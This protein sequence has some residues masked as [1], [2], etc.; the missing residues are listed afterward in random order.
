MINIPVS[1]MRFLFVFVAFASINFAAVAQT[2][3][4]NTTGPVDILD[5]LD[6]GPWQF[7]GTTQ[8]VVSATPGNTV[9]TFSVFDYD[10]KTV[11][12]TTGE[13][14]VIELKDGHPMLVKGAPDLPHLTTPIIIPN[15]GNTQIRVTNVEYTEVAGIEIAP[16]KGNLKRTINP[17]DVP[18]WKGPQYSQNQFYPTKN[19]ALGTPYIL[20]DY[21]GQAVHIYPIQ[22]NPVT[23]T[24][25][26]ATTITVEVVSTPGVGLNELKGDITHPS[27]DFTAIYQSHFVNYQAEKAMSAP[28]IGS[29]LIIT[30]PAFTNSMRPYVNW[31][32]RKG[33]PTEMVSIQSIGNTPTAIQAFIANYYATHNL[34]YVLLVGDI[35]Q[36]ASPTKSGG[37]SDPSYGYLTGTDSYAEVIVGRFSAE[38]VAH[39][40]TQVAKVL[41][42]E[43]T[44]P[45]GDTRFDHTTHIA[46]NEGPGDNNEMDWEHERVIRTKLMN[47]TYTGYNEYYDGT[48][49]GD[50]N[51]ASGDPTG[52]NI[53]GVVN[54]GTGNINYTGH[55]ST[56]SWATT[57]FSNT[58]IANLT[59]T[60]VFPFVCSVGCVNGEFDN[61]TCFGEAWLRATYNGMPTGAIAA[62]MST[63]NQSWSPP[64]AGQ[65]GMADILIGT[66]NTAPVRTFGG[67]SING[68]IYM[69]DIYGTAGDEMTDTWHCFGDPTV[70][71][72][73][74]DPVQLLAS[75]TPTTPIGTTTLAISCNTDGA[76]V[77][78]TQ[79]NTIIGTAYVSNGTANVT[80]TAPV[81]L[82][83]TIHV[84]ATAF[85]TMPY[86]GSILITSSAGPFVIVNSHTLIDNNPGN[87]NGLADYA[88]GI[89][90]NIALNNVGDLQAN[91]I[92]VKLRSNSALVNITDSTHTVNTILPNQITPLS[93]A[94][95]FT[96]NNDVADQSTVGFDLIMT[97][98]VSTWTS[99]ISLVVNAPVLSVPTFSIN[100]VAGNNNGRIDAGETVELVYGNLNS[101]HSATTNASAGLVCIDN[102]VGVGNNTNNVGIIGIDAT[103]AGTFSLTADADTPYNHYV[104]LNYTVIA[105][106]YTAQDTRTIKVN[107]LV[108]DLESGDYSAF[109]W[110]QDT[111][112]PWVIDGTVTYE[113]NYSSRSGTITDNQASV[114]ELSLN[115]L[116]NDSIAFF[117]KVSTEQ[118]YDFLNFYIDGTIVGQW[119]GIQNWERVSFPVTVGQH[120]FRWEYFKDE[121]QSQND[122]AVWVDF[123]ELPASEAVTSVTENTAGAGKLMI[124]PNP[125]NGNV[126]LLLDTQTGKASTLL[127]YNSLGQVVLTETIPA[128]QML[129]NTN[130]NGFAAGL[131]TIA[132]RSHNTVL[133]QRLV[134]K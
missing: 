93:A 78:L 18:Y 87:N 25:R 108:D 107:M 57:G 105:D 65:D 130:I 104:T 102:M 54:A 118:D 86:L 53:T 69:N 114:M 113:G 100:D 47:F 103:A 15:T 13:A 46:S 83:D 91:N 119:S 75:H 125:A 63:I 101:G 59:N 132:V 84:T 134:I 40:Q 24:M 127:L 6:F 44:P 97:D 9:L 31:K 3:N 16:S 96:V 120:T 67:I 19:A 133:T 29:L 68:C 42:Y 73:T 126:T 129:Y 60:T 2:N 17:A 61:G 30:D 70:V 80:L 43:I 64:M 76:L 90:M 79:N 45:M 7:S 4:N 109:D 48:H 28:E 72:R 77:A 11:Q 81:S 112:A 92:A 33:I 27:D 20:R 34:A 21:R 49:P 110:V 39:V 98:G 41:A 82:T 1:F 85:N 12:T 111:N 74:A 131:Y 37:K 71:V 52:A 88:E 58:T 106:A 121:I 32:I 123:V 10:I 22:Y 14:K 99:F 94:F 8:R 62:F 117:K 95:A 23:K 115:V 116:Q 50:G 128:N 51:D 35:A 56:Q 124:Y 38:N 66:I 89:G 36:I 26:V 55:G 122:D 5:R